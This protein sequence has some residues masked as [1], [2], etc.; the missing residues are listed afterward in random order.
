LSHQ[1]FSLLGGSA[2]LIFSMAELSRAV[3]YI[4]GARFRLWMNSFGHHRIS[5]FI[6]GVVLALALSSSGAATVMLVSLAN[7]RLLTLEQ[8]FAMSLGASLGST[9]VVFLFTLKLSSYGLLLVFVGVVAEGLFRADRATRMSRCVLYLGMMLF[10]LALLVE[11]GEALRKDELFQYL[12][13]YFR[14]RP[15]AALFLSAL[16]TSAVHSSAATIA[17]VMTLVAA[18]DQG[19]RHAIPWVLGANLGTSTTAVWASMREGALG[20]QA[21]L[22][23]LLFRVAGVA[24]CLPFI[25]SLAIPAA[26]LGG[27]I[28]QQVA[29]THVLFNLILA[30]A[31]LPF[32]RVG[33]KLVRRW[34][35]VE[36]NSGP[37]RFFYLDDRILDS[38]E[39]ALAQAQREILRVADTVERMIERIPSLFETDD[40]SEL[41]AVKAM[42]HIVDFL[43]RGIKRYLTKLSQSEMTPQQAQREFECLIRTNDLE[44]IGDIVDKNVIEL[45][46][47]KQKKG[48][49]FSREGWQ[50]LLGLHRKVLEC[51]KV[52]TAYFNT[53]DNEL[54]VRMLLLYSRIEEL[55]FDLSEKH[56]QR[57]HLGIQES[58][59][60]SSL[61]LDLIGNLHRIAG[62]SVNFTRL[63]ATRHNP[64]P[65]EAGT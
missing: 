38:P 39:L 55:M 17:F 59:D 7:A 36:E 34:I 13:L 8:V 3:Q 64:A 43:N 1:F 33:V 5:G 24:V 30:L 15:V 48:H 37:F 65:A 46:R 61:H 19:L 35:P 54:M 57:L 12:A 63:T 32:V 4:A 51:V 50:D 52:S 62:L 45:A 29:V 21:A 40:P 58:I 11:A 18:D 42:D 27:S 6:L 49:T 2:L 56:V 16:L 26:F 23:N 9:F 41:E 22:G 31:F 53:R 28:A 14:E 47:K 44:N 10:S 60:S 25:D 20:K